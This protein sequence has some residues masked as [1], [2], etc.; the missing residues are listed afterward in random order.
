MCS[1]RLP[2]AMPRRP[3]AAATVTTQLMA[4][5]TGRWPH[6]ARPGRQHGRRDRIAAGA[7]LQAPPSQQPQSSS[8]WWQRMGS[9]QGV[10]KTR[11]AGWGQGSSQGWQQKVPGYHLP[12]NLYAATGLHVTHVLVHTEA[13]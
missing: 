4:L 6:C 12:L 13:S 7:S 3:A 8:S 5:V 10:Y 1:C 9:P 2:L 11:W